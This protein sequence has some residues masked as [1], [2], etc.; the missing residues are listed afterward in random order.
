MTSHISTNDN[1]KRSSILKSLTKNS[2]WLN[3]RKL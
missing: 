2:T 3:R 1:E